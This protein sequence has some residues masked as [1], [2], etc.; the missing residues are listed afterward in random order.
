MRCLDKEKEKHQ[1]HREKRRKY[2]EIV[3]EVCKCTVKKMCMAKHIAA[4]K[5]N[6][7]LLKNWYNN[8]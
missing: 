1:R 5:H 3:C 2:F 7:K 6:E 4:D 8:F